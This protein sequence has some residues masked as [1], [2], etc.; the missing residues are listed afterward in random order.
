MSKVGNQAPPVN[1][2]NM[3]QESGNSRQSAVNSQM[4]SQMNSIQ[5][6]NA[7]LM[8]LIASLQAELANEPII[9]PKPS[10]PKAD[11]DGD[12]SK[13]AMSAYNAAMS[14]YNAA[15]SAH[16]A[17]EGRVN[18]LKG[19]VKSKEG[20]IKVAEG[21]LDTLKNSA[22]PNAKRLD[23]EAVNRIADNDKKATEANAQPVATGSGEQL[24]IRKQDVKREIQRV[25]QSKSDN[26]VVGVD[27][28]TDKKTESVITA[29]PQK[30]LPI[31][32]L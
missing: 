12:I 4:N 32:N 22:L 7:D 13:A 15:V 16:N 5:G 24:R 17:W 25:A 19:Q 20:D 21:K 11:S 18:N 31:G 30:V 3:T 14:A 23:Q 29:P 26:Y 10:A 8:G 27:P 28:A 2:H 6:L 9:P 1:L